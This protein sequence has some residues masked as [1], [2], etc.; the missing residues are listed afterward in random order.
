MKED[1]RVVLA[2]SGI[3]TSLQVTISI[4]RNKNWDTKVNVFVFY[5]YLRI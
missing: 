2:N 1:A 3:R 5:G 4:L